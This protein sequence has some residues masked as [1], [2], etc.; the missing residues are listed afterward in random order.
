MILLATAATIEA[1]SRWLGAHFRKLPVP[2]KKPLAAMNKD[3]L[4]PE[5]GI[6][7]VPPATIDEDTLES[8]G[9][10]EYLRWNIVDRTREHGDP[11]C[12]ANVFVTYYTGKPD[13]VPHV[14]DECMAAA[15]FDAVAAPTTEPIDV[16]GVGAPDGKVPLR[17]LTFRAAQRQRLAEIGRASDQ[18]VG[19]TAMYFFH[20]NGR[21]ATTRN[22]VRYIL[23]DLFERYAY[24]A[25]IEVSFS[26]YSFRKN[27]GREESL[28][29]A[30]P[31]LRKLLPILLSDHLQDWE[32]WT[33]DAA[34]RAESVGEDEG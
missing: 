5:Y 22:Q 24:Y 26:D 12:V 27:A 8:L 20:T 34:A 1:T 14:P 9:T 10:H 19:P 33:A 6:H 28:A 23:G 2:L 18:S 21:Y 32:T 15:G 13:M 30:G 31:L 7:V 16:P 17:V 3:R 25:K 29:A 4:A 11:L